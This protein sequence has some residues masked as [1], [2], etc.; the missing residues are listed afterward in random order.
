MIV[1][2]FPEESPQEIAEQYHSNPE[3][4]AE[5]DTGRRVLINLSPAAFSAPSQ[6]E[7]FQEQGHEISFHLALVS[8]AD[9]VKLTKVSPKALN[10]QQVQMDLE[11]YGFSMKGYLLQSRD[12]PEDLDWHHVKVYARTTI[13]LVDE[14]IPAGRQLSERQPLRLFELL[15]KKQAE[16]NPQAFKCSSKQ[17]VPTLEFLREKAAKVIEARTTSA[18]VCSTVS[19]L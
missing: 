5:V 8:E 13:R 14:V 18:A 9:L 4:K 15:S 7:S 19:S 2:L 10:L 1:S 11:Q 17:V 12:L 3:T 6:L 16:R